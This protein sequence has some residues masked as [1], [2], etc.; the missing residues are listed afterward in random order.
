MCH[1][2]SSGCIVEY[3][4]K[5]FFVNCWL[6]DPHS[7]LE[8]N[9][10]QLAEYDNLASS[11]KGF[12]SATQVYSAVITDVDKQVGRLLSKL[13]E[14]GISENTL[15]IFSSDNGPAPIWGGDTAHSGTGSVGPLRGCKA[16]LYE[17]GIRVPFIARW[18]GRVPAGKVDNT[19]TISGVDLLPTFCNLAGANIPDKRLLDGQDMSNALFGKVVEREKPL[20]WE[21][22]FSP[23]GRHIQKSPA[24]AIRKGEWKLMM[25]PDGSRT[26]LYNV[27]ENPTE[28]DNLANEFPAV[29]KELKQQL[30]A[31][32]KSLPGLEYLPE[33]AGSFDYPWPGK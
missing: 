7:T 15:V 1:R 10:E 20:M 24:L 2:P 31:W 12:T 23:W 30:L 21:Y 19:N 11:A 29:V 13:Q 22:R 14:L 5:P 9:S 33:N 17:G 16:S 32:H 28:V 4:K 25:N 18:P 27:R 8:P 6:V 3:A 26:E